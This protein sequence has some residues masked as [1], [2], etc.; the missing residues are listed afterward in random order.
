M[1]TAENRSSIQMISRDPIWPGFC[2]YSARTHTETHKLINIFN[3]CRL[4][5]CVNCK[6]KIILVFLNFGEHVFYFCIRKWSRREGRRWWRRH[7]TPSDS[8]NFNLKFCW[9]G[10]RILMIIIAVVKDKYS[11]A[12]RHEIGNS[13]E[14]LPLFL[15]IFSI[16]II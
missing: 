3:A 15:N 5:V 7:R 13:V 14:F 4:P 2:Q 10:A 12:D 6:I 8:N 1:G 11:V 9:F 16:P